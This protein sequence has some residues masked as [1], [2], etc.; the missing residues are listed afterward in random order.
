MRP[1]AKLPL[2]VKIEGTVHLTSNLGHLMLFVMCL[3]FRY[4]AYAG[5][6]EAAVPEV[7]RLFAEEL[8]RIARDGLTDDEVARARNQIIAGHAMSLQDNRGLAISCALNELYGLGF[9]YDFGIPARMAAITREQV[10]I[11]AASIVGDGRQAT[12]IVLPADT[13][14]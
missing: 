9:E 6:H 7:R 14:K 5:T 3:L 10:R 2:K 4:S 8:V 11:A 12:V 1:R 13:K